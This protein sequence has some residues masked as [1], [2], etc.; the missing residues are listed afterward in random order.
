M[1]PHRIRSIVRTPLVYLAYG[2]GLLRRLPGS[3]SGGR[4]VPWVIRACVVAAVVLLVAW[5]SE[6]TPQRISLADLAA[7][8]LSPMQDWIIVS[9]DLREESSLD[10]GVHLYRLTDPTVPDVSLL[11]RSEAPL[12][13]G[14]TT[15]SGDLEG[16]REGIGVTR[17]WV[18]SVRA[19]D[20][21]AQEIPPP[22]VPIG[23]LLGALLLWVARRTSYPAF[24]RDTPRSTRGSHESVTVHLQRGPTAALGAFSP[25][26]I[27]LA[28]GP[29]P[30][31]ALEAA[32]SP[33]V[34]LRLHS[35]HT[36]AV[37]GEL[38]ALGW[39]R[40]VI[41]VRQP[42]GDLTIAFE[43]EA[44]RDAVFAA[45]HDDARSRIGR[46]LPGAGTQTRVRARH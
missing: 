29:G 25:A 16:G 18:G 14:R 45:L 33:P 7:G 10:P 17:P 46:H 5:A 13:V 21:L 34:P 3:R 38:R 42:S 31:V 8:R 36:G 27:V 11:V 1:T 37:A 44:E 15:V 4:L 24:F 39:A 22:W 30:T 19:D 28:D 41:R 20:T 35:E 43:S 32:G 12:A 40:P 23:L 2:V 9:G 26:R 6:K